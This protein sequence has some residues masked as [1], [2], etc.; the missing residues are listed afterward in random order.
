MNKR[1]KKDI[2]ANKN[3]TKG[4]FLVLFFRTSS[5]FTKN[6]ILKIIGFPVRTLYKILVQ[7]ILGCDIS[8]NTAIGGGFS[9][10][11]GQGL[12][13][14]SD[15]EIGQYV[16]L[17]HNTTIGNSKRNSRCPIIGD[18]VDIGANSVIIGN[19]L[20]GDHSI[21]GAGS[22]VVKD[23]PPYSTVAGNPAKIINSK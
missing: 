5:F 15:V 12:I 20:I 23:V 22:V 18:N 8:D 19:V 21:I 11:H 6:I 10:Y 13:I 9:I 7:W 1:I 3:N 4:L 14:H 16:T 2:I 17:R